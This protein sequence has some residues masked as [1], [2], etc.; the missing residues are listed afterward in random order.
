[1][2]SILPAMLIGLPTF[3][4]SALTI[5]LG[6][7][8]HLGLKEDVLD[9]RLNSRTFY[10]NRIIGFLYWNMNY[11]IEHHM[12]PMVPYHALPD[13]HEEMKADCPQARPSFRAALKET[14]AAMM[15]Q[16]KDPD[17]VIISP[18]PDTAN[19]YRYGP[20]VKEPVFREGTSNG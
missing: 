16:N 18:L 5:L 12:F 11:H 2:R 20:E 13:L 7:T 10:T 19:P 15:K 8:Q 9:H 6:I 4:G 1:M 17:Y 3:Y 14:L